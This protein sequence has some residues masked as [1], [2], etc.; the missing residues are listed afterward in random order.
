MVLSKKLFPFLKRLTLFLIILT[1]FQFLYL[2]LVV[3]NQ[4]PFPMK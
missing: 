4:M 3:D 2:L 1:N